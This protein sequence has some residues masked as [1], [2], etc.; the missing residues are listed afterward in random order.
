MELEEIM[1]NDSGY[2]AQ[3]LA[4]MLHLPLKEM[5][6]QLMDKYQKNEIGIK[7]AKG[8]DFYFIK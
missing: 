5:K 4:D 1:I 8:Y 6:E 3:E 7:H 2:T